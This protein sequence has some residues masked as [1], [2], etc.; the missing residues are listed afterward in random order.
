MYACIVHVYMCV[1][2]YMYWLM[3][4][5]LLRK[6][7]SSSFAGSFVCSNPFNV[8]SSLCYLIDMQCIMLPFVY[9]IYIHNISK[10][11]CSVGPA[12]LYMY[13]ILKRTCS[14]L[15]NIKN[16]YVYIHNIKTN[17]QRTGW[18]RPIGCLIFVRH[19]PAKEPYN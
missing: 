14:V 10:R 16:M 12:C 15:H 1:Y 8:S 19:F 7:Q 11:T 18:Q 3:L 4:L 17:M 2:V 6:K 5:W 13:K 9:C